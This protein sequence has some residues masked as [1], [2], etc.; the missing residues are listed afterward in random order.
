MKLTFNDILNAYHYKRLILFISMFFVA[1]LLSALTP[2]AR[3]DVVPYQRIDKNGI[4]NIG[5]VTFSKEGINNVTFSISGQGY[6][7]QNYKSTSSMS[8]NDRTGVYEYYVPIEADDFSSDGIFTVSATVSGNDGGERVLDAITLNVN[9]T[10]D[11]IQPKVWVSSSGSDSTGVVGDSLYPFSTISGA[12][13]AIQVVNGGKADGGIVYLEEGTYTLGNC[14][15]VT[16]NEWLT[17][18]KAAGANIEST[19]ING[20]GSVKETKL[21]RFYNVTLKSKASYDKWLTGWPDPAPLEL[22]VDNCKVIGSG[23]H[24]PLTNPISRTGPWYCTDSYFYNVDFGMSTGTLARNVEMETTGNDPF[25]NVECIINAKV[26]DVDPGATY[27]HADGFQNHTNPAD[28]KIIYG[29]IGTDLHYQGMFIRGNGTHTNNAFVNVFLEMREPGRPGASTSD[30]IILSSGSLYGKYDHLIMW[31]C[32]FPT[33]GFYLHTEPDI[34]FEIR[35]SS[36]IG[37]LFYELR[38]YPTGIGGSTYEDPDYSEYGNTNNNDFLYNHY[39]WS[40]VDSGIGGASEPHWYSKSPDSSVSVSQSL[41]DP[42][43]NLSDFNS[44]DFGLPKSS[45]PLI[46]R[47]PFKTVPVDARGFIRDSNP[48]VGAL[49]Y[50]ADEP[51]VKS[52]NIKPKGLR[53][54]D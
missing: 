4:F 18:T 24:L 7:G 21:I 25:V 48:D 32:S 5:V 36:F 1:S 19:I 51:K 33:E 45:S 27:W 30:A 31:N 40:A 43:L 53:I 46:N 16:E 49:E 50:G 26:T 15:V 22:W 52:M 28:N 38:D 6:H 2:V 9:R 13:Q 11:L 42:A 12:I 8:Y 10:G 23:R 3:W 35:N 47:I 34:G 17:I 29:Y 37:N 20:G 44:D 41:G 14:S 39:I 54:I